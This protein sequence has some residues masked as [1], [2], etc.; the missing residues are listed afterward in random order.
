MSMLL[1]EKFAPYEHASAWVGT[2][3]GQRHD[4]IRRLTPAENLELRAALAFSRSRQV[5]IPAMR[6]EDFP[7][8]NACTHLASIGP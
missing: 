2:D 1:S 4:W 6:R 5:D 3:M 8:A 7:L